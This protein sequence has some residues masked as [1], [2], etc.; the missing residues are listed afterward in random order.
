MGI[1]SR[2]PNSNACCVDNFV[3]A[4][5]PGELLNEDLEEEDDLPEEGEFQFSRSTFHGFA[6]PKQVALSPRVSARIGRYVL[7]CSLKLHC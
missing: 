2:L 4:E 1:D 7:Y 6:N 3:P 5:N